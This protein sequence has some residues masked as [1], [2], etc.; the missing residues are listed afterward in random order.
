M[1]GSG[2]QG[3]VHVGSRAVDAGPQPS[4][5]AEYRPVAGKERRVL[6]GGDTGLRAGCPGAIL[7]GAGAL[8]DQ[9]ALEVGDSGYPSCISWPEEST[10]SAT[11]ADKDAEATERELR[12][13]QIDQQAG[14]QTLT[15]LQRGHP[16]AL[17]TL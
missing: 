9:L 6:R 11:P 7:A 3:D 16:L 4:Q 2:G 8:D 1:Y 17:I 10:A 5:P 14:T 12:I 15:S 13:K